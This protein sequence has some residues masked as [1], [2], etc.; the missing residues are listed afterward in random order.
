MI[1]FG[2]NVSVRSPSILPTMRPTNA[3][4]QLSFEK[5]F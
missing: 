2:V 4:R 5:V 1:H 3:I